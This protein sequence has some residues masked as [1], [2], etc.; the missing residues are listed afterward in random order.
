MAQKAN[1]DDDDEIDEFCLIMWRR[2]KFEIA[3]WEGGT[4]NW[5]E[6]Q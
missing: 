3:A 2:M 6:H 1:I 4:D 5:Y